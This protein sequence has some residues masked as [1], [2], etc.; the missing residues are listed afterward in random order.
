VV[1]LRDKAI[2]I[3]LLWQSGRQLV[4]AG[5]Y[6]EPVAKAKGSSLDYFDG[7]WQEHWEARP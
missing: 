7:G 4:P 6:V 1:E 3:D 2:D 5:R